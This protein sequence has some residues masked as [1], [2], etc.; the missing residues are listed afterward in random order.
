M[1]CNPGTRTGW[2]GGTM[3]RGTPVLLADD[4]RV[5]DWIVASALPVA[6]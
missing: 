5:Y 4:P 6:A 2:V 1:V 3:P